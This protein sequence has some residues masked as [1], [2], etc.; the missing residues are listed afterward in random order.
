[1]EHKTVAETLIDITPPDLFEEKNEDNIEQ[2]NKSTK[3]NK[4]YNETKRYKHFAQAFKPIAPP[5]DYNNSKLRNFSKQEIETNE[6]S[7]SDVG[8]SFNNKE[9]TSFD[10][11]NSIL[12]KRLKATQQSNSKELA[13]KNSSV[14][15][16]LLGRT[17]TFLPIPV[18]LCEA[19]GKIV[20]NIT[21]NALGKV[22]KSSINASSTSNN[23]CLQKHALEYAADA[24][25]STSNKSAQIGTITFV[26]QG[27]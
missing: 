9:L 19:N 21:V 8:S 13:N 12:N 14:F 1:M 27:K 7:N 17:D 4:A 3:T 20:V 24:R 2:K 18:Y 6:V 23:A 5:K 16:S 26:F 11:V 15:Y 10:N 25:F 22:I